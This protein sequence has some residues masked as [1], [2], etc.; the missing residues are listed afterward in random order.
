MVLV[1]RRILPLLSLR[2]HFRAVELHR[3]KK[4]SVDCTSENAASHEALCFQD[5][6]METKHIPSILSNMY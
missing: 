3:I 6:K 5:S 4:K 1:G 2:F